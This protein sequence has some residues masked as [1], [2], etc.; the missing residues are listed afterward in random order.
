MIVMNGALAS[1]VDARDRGLAYGDG[2][3][4]TVALRDRLLEAWPQQW[5]RLAE[6]CRALSLQCPEPDMWLDA[7]RL[8]VG[9]TRDAALKLM[10]TRGC[11]L[12]GYLYPQPQQCTWL[13]IASPLPVSDP[14]LLQQGITA[15][16]CDLR[17]S[18]QPLLAGIKHLNR[19][20]N[21]LARN[22]WQDPQIREGLLLDQQG[23]V[24]E[25]TMSNLLLLTG[26]VLLTPALE[27]CGV[28][29]VTRE[30]MLQSATRLGWRVAI[31]DV[32]VEQVLAADEVGVCNSLIGL[33][34]VRALPQRQW[35]QFAGLQRIWQDAQQDCQR[36]AL[37]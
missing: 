29:G 18:A 11:G 35:Q 21:V 15:R 12:R 6:D 3:F 14:D 26:Q 31:G 23:R 20:E 1:A 8:A 24:I 22:E 13:V 36:I 5:A 2:V 10:V 33:W 34:P 19:L 25:G 16:W 9:E 32:S 37:E 27:Q 28:A 17:L 7:I 30:R 4:R